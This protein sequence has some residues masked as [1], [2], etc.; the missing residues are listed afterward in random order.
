MEGSIRTTEPGTP[1]LTQPFLSQMQD[2]GCK[3]QVI[4]RHPD[5]PLN[6][7][8][9]P[10]A[11]AIAAGQVVANQIAVTPHG[12]ENAARAMTSDLDTAIEKN[13]DAALIQNGLHRIVKYDVK[14]GVGT[15]TG[16]VSS[17][18][19]RAQAE[20]IASSVPN[21]KQVVNELQ[22]R[23]QKASSSNVSVRRTHAESSV[24]VLRPRRRG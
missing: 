10:I 3:V 19:V 14:N 6:P 12:S 5:L 11:K 17:H 9:R 4:L 22:S 20:Q 13:L 7:P 8:G 2:S 1:G 24:G 18:S 21:V 23:S 15:L 16:A